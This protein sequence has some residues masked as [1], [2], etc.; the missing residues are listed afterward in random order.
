MC[1]VSYHIQCAGVQS[2]NF[3]WNLAVY[4]WIFIPPYNE[5]KAAGNLVA[6]SWLGNSKRLCTIRGWSINYMMGFKHNPP[7][8]KINSSHVHKNNLH[9]H[10]ACSWNGAR[11]SIVKMVCVTVKLMS[12]TKTSYMYSLHNVVRRYGAL[13]LCHS[14]FSL[15][16]IMQMTTI[17]LLQLQNI[18][19]TD[20]L[21]AL[22]SNLS[23]C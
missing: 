17:P 11:C 18:N 13:D 9:H 4:N 14:P 12:S 21:I 16:Q 5:Q 1:I 20:L 8:L 19:T 23:K 3:K 2:Q 6:L 10:L 15:S 22:A 7:L